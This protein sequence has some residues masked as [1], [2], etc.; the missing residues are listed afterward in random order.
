MAEPLGYEAELQHTVW[1]AHSLAGPRRPAAGLEV[2][3]GSLAL[4][5]LVTLVCGFLPLWIFRR[6]GASVSSSAARRKC[7]SLVSC[8]AGGVFLATCLLD[9]IPD[10]LASMNKALDDLRVT[11]HFPLQEF[12]LA[13]GFFLVLILEQIVLAYRDPLGSLEE[14][15]A[16]LGTASRASPTVQEHGWPDGPLPRQPPP[17]PR[18]QPHV[19]VDFNAH[20]A[21]RSVVLL[22]ALAL[23]SVSEGLAVG[24]Q[25]DGAQAL[26]ICLALLIHKGAVAFSLSLKLLQGRLRPRAVAACLVLFAVMSP[27]GIGLGVLLTERPAAPLPHLSRCVLEGLATGTFVYITFLEILPHELSSSEQRIL[28]VIVL[29]VG[30]ALVTSIL[31]V[32][33]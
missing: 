30:F 16:L 26:E 24:L 23:H 2:K 6:P 7:L 25:E 17:L 21:V 31:F 12:I 15:E 18:E 19:H 27:L 20:S 14:T 29:L 32:K 4:L 28:K 22:L 13:M 33:I 10:Y 8:F 11:L 5:L 3:L 9:L 1:G